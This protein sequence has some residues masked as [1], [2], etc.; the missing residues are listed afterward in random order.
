MAVELH[1]N[2]SSDQP[3]DGKRAPTTMGLHGTLGCTVGL[4]G[5]LGLHWKCVF[6]DQCQSKPVPSISLLP[7]LLALLNRSQPQD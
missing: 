5:D 2:V 1:G 7:S 4:S 6:E 3:S